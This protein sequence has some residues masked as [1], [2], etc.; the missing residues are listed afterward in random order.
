MN[1]MR[2]SKVEPLSHKQVGDSSN[3]S[4]FTLILRL[5][6]GEYAMMVWL[7]SPTTRRFSKVKYDVPIPWV[8]TEK[9]DDKRACKQNAQF[10]S[11]SSTSR[12][13]IHDIRV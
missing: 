10:D 12:N 3:L 9:G 1:R 6:K 4:A 11:S 8:L 5:D 7:Y 13:E 2:S